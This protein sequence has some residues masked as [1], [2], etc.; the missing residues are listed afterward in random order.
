[1]RGGKAR[2]IAG[3]F[4]ARSLP[5]TADSVATP[6][7]LLLRCAHR[8]P[9]T[10]A[11]YKERIASLLLRLLSAPEYLLITPRHADWDAEATVAALSN[12][13]RS[14]PPPV[15]RASCRPPAP[16]LQ[17]RWRGAAAAVAP[18][19]VGVHACPIIRGAVPPRA[20]V[21]RAHVRAPTSPP[22]FPL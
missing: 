10:G 16:L 4:A 9:P 15:S 13:V 22:H 7:P 14:G 3:V 8:H 17:P 1:M 6:S 2:S 21:A 12:L 19:V 5:L 18:H 20:R 11:P